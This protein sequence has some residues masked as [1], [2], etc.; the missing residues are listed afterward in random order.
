M[1]KSRGGKHTENPP[2]IT[3]PTIKSIAGKGERAPS[4]LMTKETQ[5]LAASVL[6]HIEP[7]K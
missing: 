2:P 3:S 7:R 1:I 4:T 6:R 5:K